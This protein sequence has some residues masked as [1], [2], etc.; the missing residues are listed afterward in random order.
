MSSIN[1]D[2][3]Y[4]LFIA[5]PLVVLFTVPFFFAVRKSNLNGHNLASLILHVLLSF[6]IAFAAAGTNIK[7]V[8]SETDVIVVAD[9]SYSA[10]KNLDTIDNYIKGLELPK[11]T[12]LG[13]VCFG[14]DY[15][16]L[17]ALGDPKAFGTVRNTTVDDSETNIAEALEYAGTLFDENVIKRVV[18]ITDGKQTDERDNYAI[19]RAVSGL[20]TK[21]VRVDAIFLDDNIKADAKEVQISSVD[22]NENTYLDRE[23]EAVV[24]IMTSVETQAFVTLY[25]GETELKKRPVSLTVGMNNVPFALDTSKA[26]DFD[27]K[28]EVVADDDENSY[29]NTFSFTQTVEGDLKVLFLTYSWNDAVAAAER[30]GNAAELDIY[31]NDTSVTYSDK[32]RYISSLPSNIHVHRENVDVPFTVEDLCKF[33]EIV[34]AN[35]DISTFKNDT[36]FV[37]SLDSVVSKFGKSLVTIGDLRIQNGKSEE[38]KRLEDI[39]P[40]R[41]SNDDTLPKLFTIVIDTSYSMDLDSRMIKQK[42][43]SKELVG[44]LQESDNICIIGFDGDVRII[45]APRAVGDPQSL[46][47]II[48]GITTRQG[49]Y[50]G[51]GMEA[52]YDMIKNL[53]YSDKQVMLMTDGLSYTDAEDDP[54]TI[55]GKMYEDDIVTSVIDVA[56]QGE[57]ENGESEDPTAQAAKAMLESVAQAGHGNYYYWP[58]RQQ[59]IPDVLFGQ[60]AGN[61]KETVID[62]RQTTVNVKRR[63]DK[64]LDGI[65]R[66]NI[67]D[68]WGYIYSFG[69]ASATNVLTLNHLKGTE[70]TEQPLLAYW[71]YGLGR[72]STF[73]SSFTGNWMREWESASDADI[74]FGNLLDVSVPEQKSESPYTVTIER[75]GNYARVELVP[76]SIRIS[77]VA[78]VEVRL[79]DG[80]VLNEDMLFENDRYYLEFSTVVTGKYTISLMYIFNDVAYPSKYYLNMDYTSEYNSFEAY[81]ASALH[82]AIDEGGTVSLSGELVIE[83]DE[84]ELGT[85]T[86]RLTVPLL[87][88]AVVIYVI[89]IIVRKLK[90]EDI[91]SFFGLK[92]KRKGGKEQ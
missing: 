91:V 62:G 87:I 58:P 16:L 35:V 8:L 44:M 63:D 70:Y 79:P 20:K 51:V 48:D 11:N 36:I 67:P 33:D 5:L 13:V 52:A 14:K 75:T 90:W 88:A 30:Y 73:T 9:V 50:I 43:V 53:P 74:F 22:V 71:N 77:T 86:N 80:S 84:R 10:N 26:G 72:V 38:L 82:N 40:V 54:V 25:S 65:D 17:Y 61:L 45:Q 46:Y 3:P 78:S 42:M 66:A 47:D 7:T 2:N 27:Y 64:T 49:T 60:I 29:N 12:K 18:L 41:F 21:N 1:F 23:E 89:D 92:N 76:A 68:V 15:E 83:N 32:E 39:L 4:L 55:A 56:R 59:E 85:Y 81:D 19:R 24:N 6:V 69:K 57:N 34:L 28:V 31:E 37:E